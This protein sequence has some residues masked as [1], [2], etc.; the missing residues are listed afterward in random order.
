[1]RVAGDGNWDYSGILDC[2]ATR[3]SCSNRGLLPLK[4][5]HASLFWSDDWEYIDV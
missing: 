1:M 2:V 3:E 4:G 5:R